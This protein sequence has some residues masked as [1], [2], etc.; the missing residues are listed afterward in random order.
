MK[1]RINIQAEFRKVWKSGTFV[2]I[3]IEKVIN[4][5]KNELN[6]LHT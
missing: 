3:F 4:I 1:I 5:K 2:L 6:L